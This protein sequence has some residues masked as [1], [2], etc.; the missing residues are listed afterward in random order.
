[1]ESLQTYRR[2]I[3][4]TSDFD[5]GECCPDHRPGDMRDA[6]RVMQD[7]EFFK[8]RKYE[9]QQWRAVR[10]GAHIL[11]LEFEKALIKKA[12]ECGIP[13]YA[14]CVVRTKEE[15]ARVFKEG[16]S[17]TPP[18]GQWAH[19]HCAVDII[20]CKYGWNLNGE[21]WRLIA[22]LGKE[23]AKMRGIDIVHGG[24]WKSPWDPAHWELAQWR[25]RAKE[26][27]Q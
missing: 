13:L 1:M 4:E 6:M 27:L 17:K 2:K 14:H 26:V 20:H 7:H 18:T 19:Q 15:Q 25:E 21:Q 5:T 12:R 3:L 24:D 22:H 10:E 8:T 23:V 11:I 9:D 16:F